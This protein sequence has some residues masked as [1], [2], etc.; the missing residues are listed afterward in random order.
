MIGTFLVFLKSASGCS[1]DRLVAVRTV[2]FAGGGGRR[3][4]REGGRGG[5][6]EEVLDGGMVWRG[7]G[8]VAT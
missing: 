8:G 4:R 6:G 1:T 2:W 3:Q 7:G 5:W